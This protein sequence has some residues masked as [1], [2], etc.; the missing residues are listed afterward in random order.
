MKFILFDIDGTLMSTG[1]AGVRALD[2]AFRDVLGVERAFD[3]ISMAGK[4]DLL[5]VKEGLAKHGQSGNN[6][7]VPRV[8]S[9][10]LEHLAREMHNDARHLKPGIQ[11]ALDTLKTLPEYTIGLLT[12]NLEAGARIKLEAF[13]IYDYFLCGAFGSDNEDRNLLLP[14]A[15]QRFREKK[16]HEIDF[17]HCIIVGDT[18]RDVAC[19]KPYGAAC[20]AV[21]TGP[22]S[23]ADLKKTDADVVMDDLADT[24]YF[25][26][27]L[28]RL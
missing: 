7:V 19:A 8:L 13:N 26:D 3:G 17:K 4:T 23:A 15:V 2:Y 16:L 21:A 18:P 12:G 6:G 28:A 20:I 27:A 25:L 9:T 22:Y 1:G 10:Y 5:I 24:A 11:Q 14:V